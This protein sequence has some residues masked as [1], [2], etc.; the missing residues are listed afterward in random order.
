MKLKQKIIELWLM[1]RVYLQLKMDSVRLSLAIFMANA[2]QKAKN[3]RF[4]VIPNAKN[5][6]IWVCNDDIKQMKKPRTVRKLVNGKLRT[7]KV[8]MIDKNATHLDIMRECLYYTPL[9]R[10]NANGITVDERNQK[11]AKWLQYMEK[12]RMD[13]MFGKLTYK[14]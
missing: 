2:L 1:F 9:N 6:L 12:I 11:K 14:K 5:Q 8:R 3:K 4:Y 7:F 13:R 10:N